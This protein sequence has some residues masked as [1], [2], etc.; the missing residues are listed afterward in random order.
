MVSR[1]AVAVCGCRLVI[2]PTVSPPSEAYASAEASSEDF[3]SMNTSVLQKSAICAVALNSAAA[4]A[5]EGA[6]LAKQLANP[7]ASLISVP[8]EVDFDRK[9]GP[10]Q[11]GDRTLLV[12]KPVVPFSLNDDWNLITRTIIPFINLD[13]IASGVDDESGLGDVQASFFFSPKAPT[14]GGW[15]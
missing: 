1:A 9:L 12:L 2:Y 14:A 4:L 3:D 11:D 13:D 6:D 15:I 5:D 10:E 7:I 8:I